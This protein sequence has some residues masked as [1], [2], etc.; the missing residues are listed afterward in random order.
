VAVYSQS[1]KETGGGPNVSVMAIVLE[2]ATGKLRM[3]NVTTNGVG[4]EVSGEC[5]AN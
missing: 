3:A 1:R 5:Q 4:E 2:K